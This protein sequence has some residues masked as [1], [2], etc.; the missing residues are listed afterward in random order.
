MGIAAGGTLRSAV[1][2]QVARHGVVT[3]AVVAAFAGSTLISIDG[4]PLE[5]AVA[6]HVLGLVLGLGAVLLIDWA[7]VAWMVG[8]RR[9]SECLRLAELAGPLIWAGI[10]LLVGSGLF[11]HPDLGSPLT[12]MK[13]AAVLVVVNNG[14]FADLLDHE[15]RRLPTRATF[16]TLPRQIRLRLMGSAAASQF[17]WWTA[18]V[19]GMIATSGRR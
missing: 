17:F 9:L 1:A 3:A 8:L 2:Q 6:F 13:I 14:V 18:M 15:L 7:G 5:V 4:V 19:I 11:L 10:V 16:E 12:W